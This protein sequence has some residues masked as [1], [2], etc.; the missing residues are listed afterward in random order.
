MSAAAVRLLICAALLGVLGACGLKGDLFLPERPAE[1][2]PVTGGD[3]P[4]QDQDDEDKPRP[5]PVG[6]TP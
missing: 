2:T 4:G 1:Q 5:A 3:A 6:T